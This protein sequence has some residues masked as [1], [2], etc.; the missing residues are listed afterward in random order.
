MRH[1]VQFRVRYYDTDQMGVANHAHYLRWLEVGRAE[2][3]RAI[4]MPVK[5]MEALG[6]HIVIK[7]ARCEYVAPARYD[8]LLTISTHLA[9]LRTKGMRFE[10]EIR[11]GKTVIARAHTV[12][13]CTDRNAK[14][15]ALPKVV[16][17]ALEKALD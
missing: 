9:E 15:T 17:T 7:E 10:Y 11:R 8:D 4:K 2:M 16:R 14:P 12:H 6:C 1:E 3:L 13:V 5:K